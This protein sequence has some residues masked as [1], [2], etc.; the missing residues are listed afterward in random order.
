MRITVNG[1]EMFLSDHAVDRYHQRATPHLPVRESALQLRALL[2]AHGTVTC[3]Q[4]SWVKTPRPTSRWLILSDTIA[5]PLN[6]DRTPVV[7]S[8]LIAGG[9]SD[10]TR[11]WRNNRRRHAPLPSGRA[12]RA[13]LSR[14]EKGRE[15]PS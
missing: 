4:P 11:K 13:A 2:V 12:R 1:M 6:D 14:R 15:W 8:C 3:H 10:D 5:F 9:I 7:V